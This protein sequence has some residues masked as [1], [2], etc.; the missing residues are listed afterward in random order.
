M[1]RTDSVLLGLGIACLFVLTIEVIA[2]PREI[3]E[4][5]E[6]GF[7]LSCAECAPI[8]EGWTDEMRNRFLVQDRA[9]QGSIHHPS[10][11]PFVMQLLTLFTPILSSHVW[12]RVRVYSIDSKWQKYSMY[13]STI[14]CMSMVHNAQERAVRTELAQPEDQAISLESVVRSVSKVYVS[15]QTIVHGVR[16]KE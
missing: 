7:F 1:V 13:S 6:D 5:S 2:L 14:T 9:G 15:I 3:G 12:Y 10:R 4:A 8:Q 11:S 16:K